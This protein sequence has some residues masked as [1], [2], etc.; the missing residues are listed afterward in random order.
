[1]SFDG[2][3]SVLQFYSSKNAFFFPKFRTIGSKIR[4]AFIELVYVT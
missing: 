3:P 1:M 2:L 4:L